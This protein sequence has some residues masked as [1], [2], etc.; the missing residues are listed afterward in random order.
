MTLRQNLVLALGYLAVMTGAL[1]TL[2]A[3]T[4]ASYAGWAWLCR[5]VEWVCG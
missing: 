5:H 4:L 3:L 1:G 2:Y